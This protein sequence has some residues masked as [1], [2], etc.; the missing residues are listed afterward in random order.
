MEDAVEP[1]YMYKRIVSPRDVAL[2]L[3]DY[4]SEKNVD[5]VWI[6]T[7]DISEW[8]DL[9]RSEIARIF[10][11]IRKRLHHRQGIDNKVYIYGIREKKPNK[12]YRYRQHYYE[13]LIGTSKE[14]R[15]RNV[16]GVPNTI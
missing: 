15:I 9:D 14:L 7:E 4:L 12:T 16:S 6:S 8:I 2:I 3:L 13:Y 10:T 5:T 1:W 11:T